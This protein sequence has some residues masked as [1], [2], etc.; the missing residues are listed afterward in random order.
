M[1]DSLTIANCVELLGGGVASVNP[2]CPGAVFR[3]QPGFDL[4]APQPTTDFV[5]SLLL[6]GER[7]FGRRASN[8]TIKLPIWITAPTRQILAAAREMLEEAVDQDMWTMTWTRDPAGGTPLPMIIDCFRAQPTVPTYNTLF[9]KEITGLQV[10]LTIPALPYGRADVQQQISFAAPAPTT[11]V[12]VPPPAPVV[13]DT[14]SQISSS[15]VTRSA[16]CAVGPWTACWDPDSFGDPGGQVTPLTY[17]ASFPAPLNLTSMTSLQMWLGLGSRYYANLEYHGKIHGLSV[18]VTLTDIYGGTLSFGR[19]HLKVPV[20]PSAQSPVFTRVNMAIPQSSATFA[21]ASAASYSLEIVNRQDTIRRLSWVTAYLDALT[22]YPGST[23]VTPVT[24]GALYTLYGLQGTARSPASLSFQQPPS[25]GTPTTITAAGAGNYTVPSLAA[26]LKVEGWGGG[27]CGAGMTIAGA[28]AGGNGAEYAAEFV[29]PCGAG[30]VIPY[31]IGAGDTP[32]ASPPGGQATIFGPAPGG[33][34]QLTANGGGSVATNS[35]AVAAAGPVSSN[36]T[37]HLGGLGRANPAG[38]YGG[39]GGSSAGPLA[40]G[41]TPVGPGTVLFTAPGTYTGSG[42]GWLCPGGVFQVLAEVWAGGGSGGGGV[43]F[44]TDGG[45]GGGGGQYRNAFIAVVPGTYYTVVVG[46]GGA[47]VTNTAGNPGGLSSFTGAAGAQVVAEPGQ[48]GTTGWPGGGLGGSGGTGTGAAYSGGAGGASYPYTGGGGSSAGPSAPG[49]QGSSPS[50]GI[51][52]SGG[53]NG[54]SGSGPGASP[55]TAGQAPGGGGGGA[56]SSGVLSGAGAAGQ[57]R[58]TYTGVAGAP[59]SAG[60]IAPSGGGNGGAGGA[61]AGSAGTAGSAPGGAGGGAYSAGTTLA[62]GAGAPGQLRITPY[63]AAPFKNL[64]AHRPPLGALKTFQP[65]VPVGGGADAPDGTHQYQMPQPLTGI[66]ADFGG[67]YSIYLISSSWNGTAARTIF[68]TVTQYEYAGGASYSSSTLPV[69]VT[70][71]Q[72]LNGVLLAGVLTLPVK[73]VAPDNV[74]GYYTV[75]VTDSNTSDRFY[76]CI[77]LDTMGQTCVINEP[78]SGYITYYLDAPDP[79]LALA[80]PMG[81]QGGRADAIAV[82]D[83]AVLS[84]GPMA[85]EPADADNQL[86]VYSADASAPNVSLAY[87]P[88]FFFDRTQ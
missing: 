68:V 7:P 65:L 3:L 5:A 47:A 66:N 80:P 88:S 39:G 11:P 29:F 48:P 23:S 81:S 8:R 71:A 69:T 31:F 77:F 51:A 53:G 25:A 52:P 62:G 46:A 74:S 15:R 1:S 21:Y 42:S 4:S 67:T 60:G 45:G 86:F 70:P 59:T 76:D 35:P 63:S 33:T 50:G 38:T 82:M 57:V 14:F 87:F 27:G 73:W 12:P 58:L 2:M 75:S 72:V 36:S 28:G 79:A 22:A 9:E 83:S 85:I 34:L 26:W 44:S 17:G 54:G 40:P 78:A 16:Q 41:S 61:S 10:T 84:G 19:G 37:E 13:L 20:S 55:G 49:N 24:R 56:Y 30:Q 43:T 64:I 6:D 32:G 18:Y